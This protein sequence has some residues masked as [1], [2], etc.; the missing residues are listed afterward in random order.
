[1]G[2]KTSILAIIPARGGSKRIPNKN[3][4]PFLGKPVLYY[5][6]KAAN[7]ARL[8]SNKVVSTDSEKIARIAMKFGA[9]V[10]FLRSAENSSDTASIAAVVQEVLDFFSKRG[11]VFKYACCIFPT[12]P[13][14]T[15][16]LLKEGFAILQKGK[17]SS[18]FPVIAYGH[19]IQR[20]LQFSG[21]RIKMIHP[22]NYFKR[23]QDFAASYHDA[24][25]FYWMDVKKFIKEK[26]LFTSN[27]G[28]IVLDELHSHDIDTVTDWKLAEFKMKF[29]Q[30]SSD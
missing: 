4:K 5:S 12:A 15:E 19:P 3:I 27:S 2:T 8:F 18:V 30:R 13:F 1:M 17:F 10:P 28:A 20:A 22:E 23:T 6:I 24:G 14:V 25:M 16:K 29:F 9:E 7:N 26:R 21:N 11:Q